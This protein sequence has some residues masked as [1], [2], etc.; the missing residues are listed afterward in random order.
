MV[1]LA[2]VFGWRESTLMSLEAADIFVGTQSTL[3]F[4]ESFCKR[5]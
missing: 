2:V 1:C 3:A 4:S 5:F